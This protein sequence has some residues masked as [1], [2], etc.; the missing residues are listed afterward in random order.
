V[1]AGAAIANSKI[2]GLGSLATKSTIADADVAAGAVIDTSKLSGSVTSIASNGLGGLAIKT[3]IVDA[4]VA[5]GAAIS[6]SKIAGLGGLA[7]KSTIADAD[8][9]AGAAIATSKLSGSVTSI[10]SNGLGGL[11]TKTTI[12]DADVSSDAAIATSK[13]S[14]P[15]TSIA[16]NGLGSLAT[17][18]TI[19]D[20]DVDSSAAIASSKIAGLGGLAAK[21]T[22]ADADVAGGAA[23]DVTKLAGADAGN[24]GKV[25]AIDDSGAIAWQRSRD[26]SCD[27]GNA[28]DVMVPVGTWCVDKY[29]A[30]IC[31]NADGTGTCYFTDSTASADTDSNY[32]AG[33]ANVPA[34]FNRDGSGS[35][36]IYAV[37]KPDVIPARGMTWYQAARACAM[38][39]KEVIPDAIWQVAAM[40]TSDSGATSGT[41]GTGGGST[42]DGANAKCNTNTN[43]ATWTSWQKPSNG[44]RPTNRSGTTAAGA[45]AC[46]SV[47]SVADMVGNLW[48]WT[49][50]NTMQAGTQTGFS[51]GFNQAPSMLGTDDQT[52]NLN[53]SAIGYNG[54]TYDWANGAP[55]AA[56]R[57][58]YWS[59]STT[60]GVFAFRM[61][62][63]ASYSSWSIGFR[64]ARPR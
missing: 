37:S 7:T 27:T 59:S 45:N 57:G 49:S 5:A 12:A 61:S 38:S 50:L 28:N 8:V 55:A 1:A 29:E 19:V 64:C 41:G 36:V 34:S 39:G 21:S 53:G 23:I 60:G 48:E 63:S 2:A 44:V 15:I 30:S 51:Q 52:W 22:V 40:G 17:K 47:F 18:S 6:N 62:N 43:N 10:A 26:R 54:S 4:D 16:S 20:A 32:P 58:G 56:L 13:L 42:A 14:G 46:L 35:A 11:A 3:T 25:L 9:A 31:S 33:A 24:K